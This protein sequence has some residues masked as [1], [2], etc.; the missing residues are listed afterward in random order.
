MFDEPV[1]GLGILPSDDEGGRAALNAARSLHTFADAATNLVLFDNAAWHDGRDSVVGGYDRTNQEMVQR[2]GTL[3][4]AGVVDGSTIAEN[5]MDASDIRRTLATGGLS[6]IAY[7]ESDVEPETVRQQGLLG[8]L[9]MS[10]E[11]SDGAIAAKK[12]SGLIRHAVRSRPTCPVSL[13]SV[14]RS[15]IVV[16]GPP[17]EFS[18]KGLEN[19]RRWLEQETGS[20]EVLAGD[21][22]RD[23]AD[24]LSAAVLLSNPPEV[25]RVQTLQ[26]QA[27]RAQ[28]L[29][30]EKGAQREDAIQ[31]LVVDEG[32]PTRPD[33]RAGCSWAAPRVER[34]RTAAG[35]RGVPSIPGAA[36]I[37]PA[38][39]PPARR[40]PPPTR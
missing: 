35:T 22:P 25:D 27:V 9:S 21:D 26:Q 24:K 19:G 15:L 32:G 12:V 20:A 11:A 8:R 23:G 18:R 10:R 30:D 3:L 29:I 5:A 28:D 16:S 37:R 13:E 6:S 31:A 38:S 4:S 1:Y 17:Q 7:A 14:E 33:L 34:V 2:L 36:L 40:G 39:A